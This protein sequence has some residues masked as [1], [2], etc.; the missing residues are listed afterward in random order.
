MFSTFLGLPALA[1]SAEGLWLT[2]PD[3]KGQV[4]H[5]QFARCGPA[6]CGTILRA[7]DA[8]GAR[9]NTPN[10]GKRVIFGMSQESGSTYQGKMILPQFKTTIDGTMKVS[11]QQMKLRGCYAGLCQTQTW[12]RLK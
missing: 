2:G 8:S 3:R 12:T 1:E 11:G 9:V 6:L 4:G 7:Y 5:V 10:V